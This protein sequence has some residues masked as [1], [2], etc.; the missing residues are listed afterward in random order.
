[1]NRI[2]RP[3]ARLFGR[4]PFAAY[5]LF[6]AVVLYFVHA[7]SPR[8]G[9]NPLP[10]PTMFLTIGDGIFHGAVPYRDLW[11]GKG[12]IVFFLTG[13]FRQIFPG[14]YTGQWVLSVLSV[15]VTGWLMYR[16]ARDLLRRD[17]Q[18]AHLAAMA[19]I[20]LLLNRGM[21]YVVGGVSDEY[22]MPFIA[23]LLYLGCAAFLH[24]RLSAGRA[25]LAGVCT[26]MIFWNKFT[27]ICAPGILAFFYML[28]CC[29]CGCFGQ[30]L[31]EACLFAVGVCIVSLPVLGY[32]ACHGALGDLYYGYWLFHKLYHPF[33]LAETGVN[34]RHALLYVPLLFFV[35]A[36]GAVALLQRRTMWGFA[37][38]TACAAQFCV[39]YVSADFGYYAQP[40]VPFAVF[41]TVAL[42]QTDSLW[43]SAARF[44]A[45]AVLLISQS[46]L[47][48][49]N[50]E[51]PSTKKS[52]ISRRDEVRN[53][54]AFLK[55]QPNRS[56]IY[57]GM[58]DAGVHLQ[59]GEIPDTCYYQKVNFDP[60]GEA[61]QQR[62]VAERH[63]EWLL[64]NA[65]RDLLGNDVT[66]E[67]EEY[68]R[69]LAAGY[70]RVQRVFAAF[71]AQPNFVLMKRD[72]LSAGDSGASPSEP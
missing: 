15:A 52:V 4:A 35:I 3:S 33:S 46:P 61:E 9:F 22:A 2:L 27:L 38:V 34:M 31:R 26:A 18:H 59:L 42:L 25:V 44:A 49:A 8:I 6:S 51:P 36:C 62:L 64:L 55:T 11:D 71:D 29:R 39:V 66:E 65:R 12:F 70:S 5:L 28:Q 57:F 19:A 20:F 13:L 68:R 37:V 16:I 60:H 48:W 30:L 63:A 1:M 56:L 41:G 24:G 72:V 43:K 67:S 32:F 54:A 21:I 53:I 10:S 58:F 69:A 40:F 7:G 23:A 45:I 50:E 14:I 17:A 47:Y